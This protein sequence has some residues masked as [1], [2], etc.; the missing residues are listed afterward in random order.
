MQTKRYNKLLQ[1]FYNSLVSAH[2]QF[3]KDRSQH[4]A[5]LLYN[6]DARTSFFQLQGLARIDTKISKH[7]KDA[8]KWLL[9]FKTL[10]D[11]FGKYDF[12]VALEEI[13]IQK[14]M[15]S[16][17]ISYL[18]TQ[19]LI[20]LGLLEAALLQ[21]GWLVKEVDSYV[22]S[23]E[24]LK[25]FTK[26][27]NKIAWLSHGKERKKLLKFLVEEIE[28]IRDKLSTG[29]IDLTQIEE[30]IH[31]LRRKLRWLGIYSSALNGKIVFP[32]ISKSHALSKYVTDKAL[33]LKFN[34]LPNNLEEQEKVFFLPGA[35]ILLGE[36]INDIGNIKDP[37]LVTEELTKIA[38]VIKLNKSSLNKKLGSDFMTHET[39]IKLTKKL[40]K[41]KLEK[42]ALL[43]HTISY[44][45]QQ[46]N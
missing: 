6:L 29:E 19:K 3:S 39:A 42:T 16:K 13:C 28:E 34:Q 7:K 46:L 43:D 23:D 25:K 38:N 9:H 40:M 15:D 26:K 2:Q 27:F 17:L 44:F 35:F 21:S 37:A 33:A 8:E 12:W 5:H 4:I 31:E 22:V 24:P 10:E 14:K 36:I 18:T 11:A 32:E 20:H 41:E 1:N 30:G 45:K